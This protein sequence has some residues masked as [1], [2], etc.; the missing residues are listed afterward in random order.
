MKNQNVEESETLGENEING[1]SV[2]IAPP[3]AEASLVT[4][5]KLYPQL[6]VRMSYQNMGS[7]WLIILRGPENEIELTFNGLYNH[8]ATNGNLRYSSKAPGNA[9]ATFWSTAGDMWNCFKNKFDLA[10]ER[11][12]AADCEAHA[13]IQFGYFKKFSEVFMDFHNI[14]K[15][16]PEYHEVGKVVAENPDNS[17]RDAMWAQEAKRAISPA[18]VTP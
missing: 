5:F 16:N 12:A 18:A 17:F 8:M 6:N 10:H 11:A 3:R 4:D 14:H 7:K 9:V 15:D 1:I 2:H 13:N